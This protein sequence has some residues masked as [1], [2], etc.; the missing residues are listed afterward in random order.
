M[1]NEFMKHKSVLLLMLLCMVGLLCTGAVLDTQRDGWQFPQDA[2]STDDTL[3]SASA[4]TMK[5][6]NIPTQRY[7]PNSR[8]NGIQIE[9]T[10]GADAQ[11]C[12]AYIFAAKS[13]GDIV[14]VWTATLTAG[15]QVSTSSRFY[16]DT[17]A[18]IT[19]N[20]GS[21]VVE[22]DGGGDN[23]V[24]RVTLDTEGHRYFFVQYTGLSSESI[25]AQYSGY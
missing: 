6:A 10:M 8:H 11:S 1:V 24:F 20:W 19:D 12:V 15:T 13:N 21:G 16:V 2:N 5:F 17:A 23:R 22:I 9:W 25:Q 3:V 4:T 14:L 18:T 7:E